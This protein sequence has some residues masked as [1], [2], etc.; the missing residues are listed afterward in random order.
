M[1][2]RLHSADSAKFHQMNQKEGDT[3]LAT[4]NCGKLILKQSLLYHISVQNALLHNSSFIF[5]VQL[6]TIL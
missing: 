5:H 2:W 6:W 1:M 4:S 3:V